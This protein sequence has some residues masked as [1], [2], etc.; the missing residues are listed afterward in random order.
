MIGVPRGVG[1][2]GYC[3]PCDMRK[4]FHTLGAIVEREMK[5]EL[6]PG[7]LFLFVSKNRKRAKVLYFDGTGM[8]LLAKRLDRGNFIAPWK[9]HHTKGNLELTMSELALLIEGSEAVTSKLSPTMIRRADL[10]TPAF[11]NQ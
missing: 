8:C 11:S 10:R 4:S 3:A 6:L 2:Y 5:C 7:D 9:R 1:V